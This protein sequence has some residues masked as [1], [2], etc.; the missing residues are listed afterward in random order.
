[1]PVA[2]A[3]KQSSLLVVQIRAFTAFAITIG[4]ELSYGQLFTKKGNGVAKK[5]ETDCQC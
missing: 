3:P 1:M 2:A 4:R 5:R